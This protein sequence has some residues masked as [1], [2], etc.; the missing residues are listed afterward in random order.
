[1]E[2]YAEWKILFRDTKWL[3]SNMPYSGHD[4][5]AVWPCAVT[6]TTW[7]VHCQLAPWKS[8]EAL[9][10]FC[11]QRVWNILKSTK[12]WRFNMETVVWV[13]GEC[14]NGWKDFT[15]EDETSVMNTRL[16][17]QLAWQLGQWNSRSSRVSVT[18][19]ESVLMKLLQNSTWVTALCTVLSMMI[20]GVGKCVA[21]GSQGS[22]PMI[23]NMH[24]RR[25]VRSIWT[26]MLVKEMLF[27]IELWRETSPGCTI[28]N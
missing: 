13:R 12:A 25:Y 5:W 21:D 6:H 7:L 22:C 26:L 4:D 24:G 27:S 15:M 16:G 17:D 10:V 8:N 20:S 9:F 3:L 19:G 23:T 2:K 11:G 14:M 1:M 18:T 28:L